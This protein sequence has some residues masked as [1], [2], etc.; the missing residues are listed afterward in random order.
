MGIFN[1]KH[2]FAGQP[3]KDLE[4]K[5]DSA[6]VNEQTLCQPGQDPE[7]FARL[8]EQALQSENE[9]KLFKI[10][11]RMLVCRN[12]DCCVKAYELLAR[13]FRSKRHYCEL[14][15][16]NAYSHQGDHEK[17]IHY[18]HAARVHG[19]DAEQIDDNIWQTCEMIFDKSA[20]EKDRCHALDQYLTL[21]PKGR[22]R[23][24]ARSLLEE[25]KK[26]HA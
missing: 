4:Q 16:A 13:K 10:A 5:P 19:A 12:Y 18:Y 6:P 11:Q 1:L 14:Q 20:R 25:A 8:F 22:H 26:H 9:E 2:I 15:I 24:A 7:N 3:G 17:S 21:C 23:R